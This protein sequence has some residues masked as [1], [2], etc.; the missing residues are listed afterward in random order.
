MI[1]LD[2]KIDKLERGDFIE[3]IKGLI[4]NS[5]QY[6]RNN[7]SD[8]YVIALDSGWG[9]GK[10][11][12]IDLLTQ[13][14]DND[15]L[16]I[17]RY[18][19]WKNDYCKNAFEPLI[20][21]ILTSEH[22]SFSIENNTDKENVKNILSQIGKIG[23]AFGKQVLTHKLK[24][25]TGIDFKETLE[26]IENSG[27]SLK[28]FMLRESEILAEINEERNAFEKFKHY[29]G[30][31]TSYLKDNNQK[32]VVIIDELDRCKPTFAIQT[33][34]IVKHLFDIDN[35]VF[36]FAV[37]IKQLSYSISSI[38][39]HDFDSAGYL[40]RF[41]DYIAKMPEADI[42]EYIFESVSKIELLQDM[43]DF[44]IYN[45]NIHHSF[46]DILKNYFKDIYNAFNFSLRDLDTIIQSYKIMVNNFLVNYNKI[47]AH[48]IYIF[49]LSLKYKYPS[50]F[51]CVFAN[52]QPREILS[53]NT[54]YKNLRMYFNKNSNITAAI[55]WIN[56]NNNL[57]ECFFQIPN[58]N[59]FRIIE[60]DRKNAVR[61]AYPSAESHYDSIGLL[62]F[63]DE[64]ISDILY[65]CD[66]LKWDDI[67]N[68]TY[69]EYIYK[70][71]EMYNF[72]NI[73][74]IEE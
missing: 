14:T 16:R 30:Q 5:E 42:S 74:N 34:E 11:Y 35:I 44:S 55:R 2:K 53:D 73:E 67:K 21:D 32:L 24:E 70:Q 69:R 50:L 56:E 15:I 57:S 38:Y 41:F 20:Y 28:A 8:S 47:S 13:N 4:I 1:C 23:L 7:E 37:D 25:S 60:S 54:I 29:L 36:L 31:A 66:L 63:H 58:R 72:Y 64:I 27:D 3:F 49:F 39:G 45:T 65:S 40:C 43:T 46:F 18:N 6:K 12:F 51:S 26:E 71:L 59:K 22:L 62:N 10:S 68:M 48:M 19:A 61:I 52:V 17:V 9:T 33:L